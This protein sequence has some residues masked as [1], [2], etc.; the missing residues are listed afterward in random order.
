MKVCYCKQA[1][2]GAI[3]LLRNQETPRGTFHFEVQEHRE[4]VFIG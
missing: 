4:L 3:T 1:S 2:G